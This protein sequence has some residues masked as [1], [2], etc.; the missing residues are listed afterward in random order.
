MSSGR[1][2][3]ATGSSAWSANRLQICDEDAYIPL[4]PQAARLMFMLVA[5]TTAAGKIEPL[6]PPPRRRN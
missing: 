6:R 2:A 3:S 1:S 5:A 4:E